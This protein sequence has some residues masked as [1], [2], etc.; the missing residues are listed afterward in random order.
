MPTRRRSNQFRNAT[1]R[2][3]A[4]AEWSGSTSRFQRRLRQP[5]GYH[6]RLRPLNPFPDGLFMFGV[7]LRIHTGCRRRAPARPRPATQARAGAVA[8]G[9]TPSTAAARVGRPVNLPVDSASAGSFKRCNVPGHHV[10]RLLASDPA[11]RHRRA[12]R[13]SCR[14]ADCNA[15]IHP[16]DAGNRRPTTFGSRYVKTQAG[17]PIVQS[18]SSRRRKPKGNGHSTVEGAQSLASRFWAKAEELSNPP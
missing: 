5:L 4:A 10:R 8:R 14:F 7:R 2:G 13:G 9:K 18:H 3:Y 6:V 1:L 15:Q 17:A 16:A 11:A 12:S